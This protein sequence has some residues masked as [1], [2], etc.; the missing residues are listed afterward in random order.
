MSD[1]KFDLSAVRPQ[2]PISIAGEVQNQPLVAPTIPMTDTERLAAIRQRGIDLDKQSNTDPH[3]GGNHSVEYF[4]DKGH[5]SCWLAAH[6]CWLAEFIH[7]E[8]GGESCR[9]KWR[10][11]FDPLTGMFTKEGFPLTVLDAVYRRR[12]ID[13]GISQLKLEEFAVTRMPWQE[14]K[15]FYALSF[16]QKMSKFKDT[17]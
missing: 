3:F 15:A 1:F 10:W 7:A 4:V 9:F 12:C 5:G 13:L 2:T 6:L 16:E 8:V 14:A 17:L 11:D